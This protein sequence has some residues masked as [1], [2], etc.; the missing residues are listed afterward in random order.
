VLGEWCAA[1][2]MIF[3]EWDDEENV[4]RIPRAPDGWIP[5]ETLVD[6]GITQFFAGVDYGDDAAGC[7]VVG[8]Y[9]KTRKLIIIGEVYARKKDLDWWEAWVTRIHARY[10]ITLGFCDHNRDDWTRAFNDVVGAPREGTGQVFVKADKGVSR[11]LQI[12]RLRIARRTLLFDADALLHPPDQSLVDAS[13]PTC[14]VDEIPEY[15]YKRDEDDDDE[16]SQQK[17]DDVPDKRCHDHGCDATRYLCVGLDYFEPANRLAEPPNHAYKK[18][19]IM[20]RRALGQT[21]QDPDAIDD[22]GDE[23]G[24]DRVDTIRRSV[25]GGDPE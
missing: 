23:T 11:G 12:M 21:W 19:L 18:R 1:E 4:V 15:I 10:P 25:W 20:L 17:P 14:T 2:G 6:L 3:E 22:W 9:T 16:V 5:R 24:D 7:M 8:G 13:L